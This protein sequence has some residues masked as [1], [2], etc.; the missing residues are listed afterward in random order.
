MTKSREQIEANER[1]TQARKEL[2][3]R[4]ATAALQGILSGL[5]ASKSMTPGDSG[6]AKIAVDYADALIAELD[7]PKET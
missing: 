4:I 1:E 2:R 5:F 6:W 7:K 3:A